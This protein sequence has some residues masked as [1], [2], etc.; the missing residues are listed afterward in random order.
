MAF[1]VL[2]YHCF[3][4]VGGS[5]KFRDERLEAAAGLGASA[6][7]SFFFVMSGFLVTQSWRRT[8][9]A[10][11]FLTKRVLRIYPAFIFVSLFCA[12]VIGPLGAASASDYFRQFHPVGFVA[13][14][15]LLVGPYLPPT[16][17]H[18][19][20]AG[21]VANSFWT[22]RYEFECYLLVLLL[23]L[24]GLVRRPAFILACFLLAAGAAL[25]AGLGHGL[26]VPNRDLHLVGNPVYWPHFALCFLSGMTFLLYRERIS[27]ALPWR[28]LACAALA[29]GAIFDQWWNVVVPT[30]GAYLLFWL[31]FH[32]V[33]KLA[34]FAKYGDFS[35]GVYLFAFPV[36]QIIV[37]YF[38]PHLTP[39]RLFCAAFPLTLL[40]AILS[41][42]LVEKP[43]LRLKRGAA[44]VVRT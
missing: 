27:F 36:Q 35:Y 41:W 3:A 34:H 32:P 11:L 39:L 29:A 24:T 43:A 6:A 17:P 44:Q 18:V 12:F 15:V 10:G 42:H 30:A 25:A 1:L 7:V 37:C 40:L 8:P 16:L 14:M 20:Y 5:A 33:P 9:Q 4:L 26:P 2:F 28:L 19:P 23:G 13:Y 22:L 31:A 38:L 21:Q